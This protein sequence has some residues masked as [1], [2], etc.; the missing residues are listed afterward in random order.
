MHYQ[1]QIIIMM[2]S[3]TIYTWH[4]WQ[5]FLKANS[6]KSLTQFW[7]FFNWRIICLAKQPLNFRANLDYIFLRLLLLPKHKGTQGFLRACL[8]WSIEICCLKL[9]NVAISFYRKNV[10][11]DVGL[12][13]KCLRQTKFLRP[14][15]TFI[16]ASF[17]FPTKSLNYYCLFS[18]LFRDYT[19]IIHTFV[20]LT[21]KKMIAV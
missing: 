19:N 10:L 14:C 1:F 9:S 2:C 13:Q 21:L 6:W 18:H 17:R 5:D 11:C 15:S 7:L 3:G 8:G 16:F 12:I 20:L 4:W